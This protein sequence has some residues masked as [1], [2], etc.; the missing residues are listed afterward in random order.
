[1]RNMPNNS[2]NLTFPNLNRVAQLNGYFC[3]PASLQMLLS[4]YGIEVD[5][6]EIVRQTGVGHKI[7]THG[8]TIAEM[9]SYIE[10]FHPQLQFWYKFESTVNDLSQL[11][12]Q[13]GMP[14][15]VEWQ[16]VFDY[17][18]E[19]KYEDED[20]DP[21]HISVITGIDTAENCVL[22]A[23]PDR[24]Y[25]GKDRRFSILQFVR[26]WW[27]INEIV[28]PITGSREENDDYQALFIITKREDNF[29]EKL[30]LKRI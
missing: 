5:Q 22:I 18:D 1:M 28:D 30:G 20:D 24:H 14:V 19:E 27:D 26:R 10:R 6:E 12:N 25:A 4:L 29:P 15:G 7:Q 9:G 16:G 3:G 2:N 13:H 11:V 21:G 23:D 8:M 17:P